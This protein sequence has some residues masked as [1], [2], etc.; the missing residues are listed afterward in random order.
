MIP[1]YE[2]TPRYFSQTELQ[3]LGQSVNSIR[4][5]LSEPRLYLKYQATDFRHSL[6]ERNLS[7]QFLQ[8]LDNHKPIVPAF[9]IGPNCHKI[10]S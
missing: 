9:Q 4:R 5:F 7:F 8:Q 6:V 3:D 1:L 2:V 10:R